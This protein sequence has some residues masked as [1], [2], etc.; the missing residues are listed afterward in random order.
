M[1]LTLPLQTGPPAV[2]HHAATP[3]IRGLLHDLGRLLLGTRVL[4]VATVGA[5][6][7]QPVLA[8]AAQQAILLLGSDVSGYCHAPLLSDSLTQ[9]RLAR[10]AGWLSALLPGPLGL[11]LARLAGMYDTAGEPAQCQLRCSM[12]QLAVRWALHL[13]R[14]HLPCLWCR[15]RPARNLRVG[16]DFPER[17]ACAAAAHA[18]GGRPSGTRAISRAAAAAEPGTAGAAGPTAAAQHGR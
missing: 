14:P 3:G 18:A 16:A 15:Q 2:L 9:Q 1:P 11:P 12:L 10:L 5:V 13:T 7:Q 17:R 6:L 8:T 4:H